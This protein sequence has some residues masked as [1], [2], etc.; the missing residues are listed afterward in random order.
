[1]NKVYA[2]IGPPAAG[3]TT[4]QKELLKYGIPA[5]LSHTT[6]KPRDGEQHGTHYYFVNREEFQKTEI[7]ERVEY[8]GSVYGLSKTEVLDK[9]NRHPISTVA[10]ETQGFVQLKKLLANRVAS[11]FIMV[12]YDTVISRLLDRGD[13][14]GLINRRLEY[15]NSTGEFNNWQTADYVVKNTGCLDSA[16][17]QIL[18]ITGKLT[19]APD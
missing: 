8:S 10:V 2:L 11:I 1:M 19:P 4:I 18:A 17:R 5:M 12:D 9:V 13:N 15:A 14:N 6:R 3:K 7:I 16:V